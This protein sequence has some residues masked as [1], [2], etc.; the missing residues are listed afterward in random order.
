MVPTLCRHQRSETRCLQSSMNAN[1]AWQCQNWR[2]GKLVKKSREMALTRLLRRNTAV[3]A[4]MSVVNVLESRDAI[5][6]LP[7]SSRFRR[8]KFAIAPA[9]TTSI[10]LHVML[11][12]FY[13]VG[14]FV[15][16][17]AWILSTMLPVMNIS[18]TLSRFWNVFGMMVVNRLPSNLKYSNLGFELNH[19]SWSF[20]K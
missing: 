3:S 15:K 6:P 2:F 19:S 14:M 16:V 1:I 17:T 18:R 8:G 5:K 20:S 10:K 4:R 9:S 12:I 13:T 7:T 11:L